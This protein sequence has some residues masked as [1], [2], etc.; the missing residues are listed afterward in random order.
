M[1]DYKVILGYIATALAIASYL[2]YFYGIY[3]GKTK[4]HAF[5]WFVWGT[6]N[7]VAFAAVRIAGGASGAWVLAVN[8]VACYTIAAVGFWQGR[9]KYD[10]TDWLALAGAFLGIILWRLTSNPLYAVILVSLSDAIGSIPIFRKAYRLPFEEN[11]TSFAMGVWY[12]LLAILAL[13]SLTITTWLY[14]AIVF[15]LDSALVILVLFRRKRLLH[16][17]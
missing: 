12:Y 2:P 5:T 6:L 7:V 4:P 1:M 11:I 9:V 13:D 3:Q 10:L 8:V 17:S 16:A 15:V 14:P